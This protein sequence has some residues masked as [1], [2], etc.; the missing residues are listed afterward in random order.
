MKRKI[1]AEY[2]AR[3]KHDIQEP[4]R[5]NFYST[6]HQEYTFQPY[7]NYPVRKVRCA[8]T[9]YRISAHNLRIERDRWHHR[10]QPDPREECICRMCNDARVEDEFH[11]FVC[12]ASETI[13]R[14]Y[15]INVQ[16]EEAI[17]ALVAEAK[18][19]VLWFVYHT[20]K[21]VDAVYNH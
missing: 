12:P 13:R 10:A 14:R 8:F 15:Q 9:R 4:S 11:I 3:W 20:L 5:L 18:P 16:S 7:L 19:N 2:V 1:V 17:S 6:L 21:L